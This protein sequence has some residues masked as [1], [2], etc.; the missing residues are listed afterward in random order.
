MR[1]LPEGV[2]PAKENPAEVET[3]DAIV[4]LVPTDVAGEVALHE[5]AFC[6]DPAGIDPKLN[7]PPV[8][9]APGTKAKPPI[10]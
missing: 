2:P 9:A 8:P 5:N 3:A 6:D 10:G 4:V 1:W 7:P